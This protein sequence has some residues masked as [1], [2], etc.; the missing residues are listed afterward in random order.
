MRIGDFNKIYKFMGKDTF[1]YFVPLRSISDRICSPLSKEIGLEVKKSSLPYMLINI[2]ISE[3]SKTL[4]LQNLSQKD[5]GSNTMMVRHK[6]LLKILP[7]FGLNIDEAINKGIIIVQPLELI[8]RQESRKRAILKL[9]IKPI[10][11]RVKDD[12]LTKWIDDTY[13]ELKKSSTPSEDRLYNKLHKSLGNR[14]KRQAP[15]V[16]QGKVFY[17]D[18]CIKSLKLIIEVDGGYHNTSL[19]KKKDMGRDKAFASIGYKTIRCSNEDACSKKYAN[20]L[21]RFI[22]SLKD[23]KKAKKRRKKL[24]TQL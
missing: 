6:D 2:N 23:E 4:S 1:I 8:Q 5:R 22:Q 15:F 24:T 20:E 21:L 16:I 17:A 18:L 9:P 11:G 14:I 12:N 3:K 13:K 7:K 19:Q 10:T